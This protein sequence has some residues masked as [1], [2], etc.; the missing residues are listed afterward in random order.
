M[1][2]QVFAGYWDL[3]LETRELLLCPRSRRMFGLA[4][5]MPK[6]LPGYDWQPRI[7][8]DDMPTIEGELEVA[9][10]HNDVYAARFRTLRP[11]GSICEILGVGRATARNPKRFIGLNLDL[12]E[13]AATA[14]RESRSVGRSMM[15]LASGFLLRSGPANENNSRPWM[16]WAP[17]RAA[18]R[19][20][21]RGLQDSRREQLRQKAQASF[22]RRQL[23]K[24]FLSPKLLGEPGF[25]ILLALYV[26]LPCSTISL[27]A[28]CSLI[29]LP[30]SV[31]LRWLKVLVNEGL[32]LTIESARD[33]DDPE[34]VSAVLTDKGRIV[35]D[36]YFKASGAESTNG[37]V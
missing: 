31:A 36:E 7:H 4:G 30:T 37:Q 2:V 16:A 20:V 21:S 24:I 33:D 26:E 11:D 27:P 18:N 1:T 29:D 19:R 32:V 14:E 23:R 9:G 5:N 28:I 35:L 8:P 34:D 15:S 13:A 12:K 22:E 10:R 17:V 3:D 25:D 6:R